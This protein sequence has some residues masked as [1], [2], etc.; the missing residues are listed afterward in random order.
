MQKPFREVGSLLNSEIVSLF[1]NGKAP[2]WG[3]AYTYVNVFPGEIVRTCA[4]RVG[5]AAG[6]HQDA[7]FIHEVGKR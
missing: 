5:I 1:F 2:K 6:Y 4:A 3:P 7:N